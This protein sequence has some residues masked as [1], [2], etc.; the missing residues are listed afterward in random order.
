[1]Q[2]KLNS[3]ILAAA[4]E[5]FQRQ[6][7]KIDDKIAEI[8]QMLEGAS[9]QPAATPNQEAPVATRKKF[10]AAA[11]K[12]MAEAQRLRYSKL[13]GEGQS[14]TPIT[15]EVSMESAPEAPK[16]KHK[17]SAEGMKRIIAATKKRWA[18]KRAADSAEASAPVKTAAVK[19]TI[20]KAPSAP[21]TKKNGTAVKK[22][23]AKKAAPVKKAAAKKSAST[24]AAA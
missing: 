17:I 18:D 22:A 13:R 10:S 15:P 12:R 21:A 7:A 8:R 1:V 24:P 20:V 3:D 23:A 14:P 4:I 16:A 2:T 6:K 11:R 5:G 9:P 19:K